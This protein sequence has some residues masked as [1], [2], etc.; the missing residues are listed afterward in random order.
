M[1]RNRDSDRT[2][3]LF[4]FMGSRFA[5]SGKNSAEVRAGEPLPV[6]PLPAIPDTPRI[7]WASH[8]A[9]QGSSQH[10]PSHILTPCGDTRSHSVEQALKTEMSPFPTNLSS[11]EMENYQ[12]DPLEKANGTERAEIGKHWESNPTLP[13][14]LMRCA[15]AQTRML[16][17][18]DTEISALNHWFKPAQFAVTASSHHLWPLCHKV[19]LPVPGILTPGLGWQG[20]KWGVRGWSRSPR[21]GEQLLLPSCSAPWR[22]RDLRVLQLPLSQ[23]PLNCSPRVSEHCL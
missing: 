5:P 7:P 1:I 3:S 21:K 15:R 8:P 19:P 10:L 22:H 11:N 6:Q 13:I 20:W 12:R 18:Q 17:G 9:R 2:W 23:L 14:K 4:E 16:R